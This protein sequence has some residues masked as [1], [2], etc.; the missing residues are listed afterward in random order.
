L[1]NRHDGS[2]IRE[3]RIN[4]EDTPDEQTLLFE[5]QVLRDVTGTVSGA[6]SQLIRAILATFATT[7]ATV[8]ELTPEES[9]LLG[10]AIADVIRGFGWLDMKPALME[11][12]RE[13][14]ALGVYRAARRFSNAAD[15]E[16]ASRTRTPKRIS[17]P[18]PDRALRQA[19]REAETLARQGIR[20]ETD[21]AAVAS[22]VKAGKARIEGHA[23]SVAN[24]GINAG[25]IGVARTMRLRVIWVA[26]RNACLHCLAHA[27]YVVEPGNLFPPVSFDPEAKGVLAVSSCPLHPNCRCQLRTTDLPAGA[28]PTD[29]SSVNPA[30]RL[31]AEARRSVVYQWT[32]YASSPATARAAEALLAA[33]AGLPASVEQRARRMLR[34]RGG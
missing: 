21:A 1:G 28:P 3:V 32:D 18:N 4:G 15:R 9:R 8:E 30:A 27:G 12:A 16:K 14:H 20:T 23:R 5:A 19:L 10:A 25:T 26:E 24:G 2:R 17:V 33:G 7:Q 29:R 31:A 6:L 11:S 34:A 22:K 13:A